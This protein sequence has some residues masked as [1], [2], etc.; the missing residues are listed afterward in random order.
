[1][2]SVN[3]SSATDSNI[4]KPTKISAGAVA[5]EGID[6]RV[7]DI[8]TIK[9]IDEE[10]IIKCAKETKKLIS[11]EDHNVIGGLRKCYFRGF[12]RKTSCKIN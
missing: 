12:N 5:K 1:M 6:V 7:I 9:P 10:L 2:S 4:R 11:I 3:F 8:H